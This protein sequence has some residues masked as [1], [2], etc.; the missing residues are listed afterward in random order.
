MAMATRNP[1][2]IRLLS[3]PAAWRRAG[4]FLTQ[5]AAIVALSWLFVITLVD[6]AVLAAG[7]SG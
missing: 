7:I 5:L 1:Q 2:A 6:V 4:L 3:W